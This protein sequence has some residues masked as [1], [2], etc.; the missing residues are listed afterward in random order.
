[1]CA[2]GCGRA[3]ICARLV[4]RDWMGVGEG[5]CVCVCVLR[6]ARVDETL[7]HDDN[8]LG[9]VLHQLIHIAE[10]HT[11][12]AEQVPWCVRVCAY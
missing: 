2:C 11:G 10:R 9:L 1:M 5:V 3:Y 4:A 12:R 7:V 6:L 8:V